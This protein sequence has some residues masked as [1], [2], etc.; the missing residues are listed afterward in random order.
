MPEP[1]PPLNY[2]QVASKLVGIDV[3]APKPEDSGPQQPVVDFKCPQ[4]GATTAYS[5][6]DGGLTC[7][8]C[9]YY[10]PPSKPVVGK[11]AQEFE[12]TVETMERAA[13][14]WGEPRTEMECK[15]CGARTL[16]PVDALTFTCPFCG[17]NEVIQ[18]EAP[19]DVLR[20]RF[21]VPFKVDAASCNA[22]TQEWLGS[23]WMTPSGLKSLSSQSNYSAI[24]LPYWTFDSV[25]HAAWKAEVGHQKTER[26]FDGKEW[27]TRVVTEWRWESGKVQQ[28]FE[29][30]IVE[31]TARL[32][33]LLIEKLKNFDLDQLTPYDPKFL[34][35][36]QARAY[37]VTLEQAWQTARQQM[38]EK[39]RGACYSQASSTQ[40]RNFS[41]DLDFSDEKWRYVLLPMY[42][43]SYR[44]Q[45]KPYQV[46]V[47][48]QTGTIAGQRPVDWR[49]V[50]LVAA[51]IAAPGLVLC[52][53]GLLTLLLGVGAAIGGFGLFLLVI[54]LVI[55]AVLVFKAM[56][57]DDI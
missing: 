39:T 5:V 54:G 11:G 31:G 51:L 46:M 48:G 37:D 53:I 47:N 43:A 15:N 7:T 21:L 57:L 20:P 45:D 40:V 27:R 6:Q 16:L 36:M 14:G 4:C 8:H 17:S 22:L 9:G 44:Y 1:F 24:Y 2:V 29:D 41:M 23:S 28:R 49:R 13:H 35:G 50:G 3:F 10:E 34:A 30:L 32:S 38:R 18:R 25:T 12:F 55:D 26:Y 52:L 33:R 42:V 56:S 19:Q